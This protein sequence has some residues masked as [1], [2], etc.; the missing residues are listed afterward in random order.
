MIES[1][2]DGLSWGADYVA[3]RMKNVQHLGD[4]TENASS[5]NTKNKL[6]AL[7]NRGG[8]TLSTKKWSKDYLEMYSY[9]QGSV[10]SELNLKA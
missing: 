7:L 5:D 6:T 2:A 10:F 9:F 3:F 8:L 4:K 1:E